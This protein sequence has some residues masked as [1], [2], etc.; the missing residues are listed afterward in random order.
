LFYRLTTFFTLATTPVPSVKHRCPRVEAEVSTQ[1]FR[2][3]ED[4]HGEI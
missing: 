4:V 3:K 2:V 1:K